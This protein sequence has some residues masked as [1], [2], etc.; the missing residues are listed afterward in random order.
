MVLRL[1]RANRN[2]LSLVRLKNNWWNHRKRLN[3]RSGDLKEATGTLIYDIV[4]VDIC[5]QCDCDEL[6]VYL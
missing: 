2:R 6:G 1:S 4:T 5:P 3:Q